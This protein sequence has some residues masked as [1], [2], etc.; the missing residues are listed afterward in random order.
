[1]L[2]ELSSLDQCPDFISRLSDDTSFSDTIL[3]S[4]WDIM[5]R[6]YLALRRPNEQVLGTFSGD[7]LT[8][9]FVFVVLDDERYLEMVIGLSHSAE[10]YDE[11]AGYL[12]EHYSGYQADFVFSP[13]N[14]LLRELLGRKGALFFPEQ[15]KMLFDGRPLSVDTDGTEPLSDR[16][17]EEYF[18]IHDADCYWTGERVAD[19]PERFSVYLAIDSGRVV[20]YI[21]VTNCFDENEPY[22]LTVVE[23]FRRRGCGRKLLARA[24][25]ANR[26]HDMMLQVDTDNTA[27]IALYESLGFEKAEGR[28]TLTATWHI[29]RR[30]SSERAA[31]GLRYGDDSAGTG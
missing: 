15:Q 16:R 10:A 18:A 1:M 6:L 3:S 25:E 21:D 12:E 4:P 27:A 14:G 23:E 5:D 19:A 29:G 30:R 28:N 11:L 24:L 17:R 31:Q 20:G 13:E 2:R 8:G 22:S 26:G 7:T 9:L